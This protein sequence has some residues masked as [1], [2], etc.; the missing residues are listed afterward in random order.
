MEYET[1]KVEDVNKRLPQI[2]KKMLVKAANRLSTMQLVW[3]IIVR[4]K[5]GIVSI[6]AVL[7]AIQTV[8]PPFWDIVKSIIS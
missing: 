8:F 5:F 4:H 3:I 7:L 6:I 1:T 2:Q